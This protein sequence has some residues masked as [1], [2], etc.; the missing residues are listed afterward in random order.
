MRPTL[1]AVLV[2][3]AGCAG[4]RAPR[5]PGEVLG[6]RSVGELVPLSAREQA[7]DAQTLP[8]KLRRALQRLHVGSTRREIYQNFRPDGGFNQPHWERSHIV[9]PLLEAGTKKWVMVIIAYRPHEMPPSTYTNFEARWGWFE[10][11]KPA[12]DERGIVVGFSN[13]FVADGL[14]VD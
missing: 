14:T 9:E 6:H 10:Q 12:G 4:H 13:A 2:L 7:V 8:R 11:Q 5:V 1:I 3:A